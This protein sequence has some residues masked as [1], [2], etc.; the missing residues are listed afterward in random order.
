MLVTQFEKVFEKP[1]YFMYWL[2][3]SFSAIGFELILFAL[4]VVLYDS[5]KTALSMGVF[6]AIFMFCLVVFGPIAGIC[7]DRWERKK[8]FITCNVLLAVLIF[9]IKYFHGTFWLYLFWFFASLLLTFLRPVRVA[10]IT[11][12][13]PR[14]DY[15]KANSAFMI[16]LNFSKIAGPLIG[17]FLIL[18][19]TMG[20]IFNIIISFFILSS[21]FV[22]ALHFDS[23]LPDHLKQERKRLDWRDYATGIFFILSHEG[24]RF[25]ILIG[26]L[27]RLFLASQLPLYIVFVKN[28]LGGSAQEYS[29]F[30]TILALGGVLGSFLAGSFENLFS[31]KTLIYGGLF[32]SYFFFTLLPAS[33]NFLLAYILI[34]L[35]N[36]FFYI[37]H[38]AI[39][40]HIQQITPDEIRGKVFG[41]S[42]TILIPIG[43]LSIFVATPLADKLGVEWIFLF[44]GIMAMISLP[45]VGYLS[46]AVEEVF[47][48][49][50][51]GRVSLFQSPNNSSN[52][53]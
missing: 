3:Y 32:A 22:S 11:N 49:N 19:L 47:Q 52:L 33:K 16:S 29:I 53:M 21:I 18:S 36:L 10:L 8:I 51:K 45:W 35:S 41:S 38:V 14:E 46:K 42:G 30:M 28:Y 4:M 34:G 9:V 43:L 26:F 1:S 20:W 13:F 5:M 27:W 25:Y 40:S 44:S 24:L 50:L 39:H 15:F 6:T 31:R 17:G 37:A 23:S 12:L 2:A 7:V 48:H